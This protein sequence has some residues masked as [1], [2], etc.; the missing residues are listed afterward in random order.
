MEDINEEIATH[1]EYD[2]MIDNKLSNDE[3]V[4]MHG[5]THETT[6]HELMEKLKRDTNKLE[7]MIESPLRGKEW[8]EKFNPQ[9]FSHQAE[10]DL[11]KKGEPVFMNQAEEDWELESLR[12]A[13]EEEKL[14]H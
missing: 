9:P 6:I 10:E 1:E 8:M 14:N 4:S 13:T 12:L 11:E 5:I 3:D 7:E 2:E